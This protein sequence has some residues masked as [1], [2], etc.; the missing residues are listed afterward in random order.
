MRRVSARRLIPNG[1]S[2]SGECLKE[3]QWYIRASMQ[4]TASSKKPAAAFLLLSPLP[5]WKGTVQTIAPGI[6]IRR[7][8]P[9][10]RSAVESSDQILRYHDVDTAA[11]DGYWLCHEF[12]AVVATEAVANTR[13]QEAAFKRMLHA[14]YAIQI[15]LPIGAPNL[16]LLYR[17]SNDGPILES[18]R[19]RPAYNGTLWAQLCDSPTEF[20]DEIAGLLL[21][22]QDAFQK[23]TLRLQIAIWLFEQGLVAPDRHIRLLLWATGLDGITRSGGVAAYSDRLCSLLGSD[24]AVF[25]PCAAY[26]QPKYKVADVV[27]DL[28]LLRTEMAHGLPF[29]EKF[30][31]THGLL[32]QNDTPIH[33]DFTNWRYD[34]VLEECS[35]F[36]LCKALRE[37][38]L[39]NRVFDVKTG[40][41]SSGTP[42]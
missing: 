8:N 6:C 4:S 1:T 14:M 25:P 28:Y 23:P 5:Q 10:E 9:P 3:S 42:T 16:L 19:H 38:L 32:A 11:R 33:P 37:I 12:E 41:W 21:P 27:G 26:P 34:R 39:R 22:I 35:A 30:R 18:T 29:H 17:Q 15:L 20:H 31:K 36:L 24:T 13:R 2:R 40:R 7:L